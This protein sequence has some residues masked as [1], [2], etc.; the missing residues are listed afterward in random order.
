M[1]IHKRRKYEIYST[2][3]GWKIVSYS[4]WSAWVMA[5]KRASIVQIVGAFG[6]AQIVCNRVQVYTGA[7]NRKNRAAG[8]WESHVWDDQ[9]IDLANPSYC[10][11]SIEEILAMHAKALS[12][13]R[14]FLRNYVERPIPYWQNIDDGTDPR[15][16]AKTPDFAVDY[17]E[18]EPDDREEDV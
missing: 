2:K 13:A 10:R 17:F 14:Q 12:S 1:S 18:E 8:E 15:Y 11:R 7:S 9:L 4:E 3:D 16:L 6:P 5:G